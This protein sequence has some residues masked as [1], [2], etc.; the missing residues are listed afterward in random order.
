MSWRESTL[1]EEIDLAYGK[2]LQES[3]RSGG[4]VPV[5]GSNGIVG[6][7]N[8]ALLDGPGIVIGR[9]GSVGAIN[10][11]EKPF[12]PIDTTYYVVNK[13]GHDWKF[14][15]FLLLTLGLDE[16]NGHAVVPGLNRET[17]YAVPVALPLIDEQKKIAA[18]LSK[19]QAAVEVESEL[20]R[21]TRELKQAALRQ[22]FTH[23]LRGEP[24]K[25]TE[26]G[27]IPESWD[28]V[29]LGSFGPV[30]NGSTPRR[31]EPRYWKGGTIPWLT[32]AMVYGR[33]VEHAAEFVTPLAVKECHLPKVPRDSLIIAITG[34]GKTLGHV[35]RVA[36]E[37]CVSQHVAFITMDRPK[38]VPDFVRQYLDTRYA[39]FRQIAMGGGS[40][41]GALT[42]SFLK[43]YPV[44]L[45]TDED[46]QKE[47]V[48]HLAT[49]DAKL[50]HHEAR[51]KLLRELFRTLLRDLL[52]ARR[53]VTTL[54]LAG[55][56][57]PG[58]DA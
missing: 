48:G 21:V 20:I 9:K 16:M 49:I 4:T 33:I 44:P 43:G 11:S 25:E 50:A 41:K 12:W 29:P 56:G 57:S 15:H 8:K 22:L 2:S 40:T 42:C 3:T 13:G 55:F 32:S 7:H 38:V 18:V 34:Q 39:H 31:T 14:L 47:I 52:T 26:I 46:E 53:R 35:A 37:T 17:A 36:I 23:G 6:W 1:G 54:D 24:Q 58:P 28:V 10:Y 30:G 5:Y 27:L 51:Q 45:P 19:V